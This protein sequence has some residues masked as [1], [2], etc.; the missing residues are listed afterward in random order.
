RA[1]LRRP[2]TALRVPAD[3]AFA[4]VPTG[5]AARARRGGAVFRG[6]GVGALVLA[7]AGPRWPDPGTRLTS[8]GIAIAVV[9]DF[10]GSMAEPDFAWG[11]ATIPRLSA[12]KLAVRL[13]VSGG[14][15]NG[16]TLP[17]PAAAQIG[18]LAFALHPE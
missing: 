4:G 7:L 5:R 3:G 12:A 2:R 10:S 18:V 16:V 1:W 8:E 15:E 17:G 11:G 9:L 6:V 14:D 13:L